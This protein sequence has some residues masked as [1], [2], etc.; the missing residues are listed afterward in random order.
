MCLFYVKNKRQTHF[1]PLLCWIIRWPCLNI[2]H[3]YGKRWALNSCQM[4]H[5]ALCFVRMRLNVMCMCEYVSDAGHL[6][7]I[8]ARY[9]KNWH[10][11]ALPS[12]GTKDIERKRQTDWNKVNI[13]Q[14]GM[15]CWVR[16]GWWEREREIESKRAERHINEMIFWT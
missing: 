4:Y 16:G 14:N 13:A 2:W 10:W 15:R 11:S 5:S 12:K 6:N 7:D 9:N 1:V 3:S 8:W